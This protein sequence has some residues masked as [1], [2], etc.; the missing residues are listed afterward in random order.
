MGT[1]DWKI[2]GSVELGPQHSQSKTRH[3]IGARDVF[4]FKRLELGN[5]AGEQGYYLLH[6]CSDDTGTDTW[7][8]TLDDAL[9]QAEWEFGV[10]RDEWRMVE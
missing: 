5:Y 9:H 3:R 1:P 2:V 4:D 8:Q 6:I 7:H 10:R